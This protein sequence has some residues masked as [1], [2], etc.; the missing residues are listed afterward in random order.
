MEVPTGRNWSVQMGWNAQVEYET[1]MILQVGYSFIQ[2]DIF[3]FLAN[4]PGLL[5]GLFLTFTAYD[6][7]KD[8]KVS[9]APANGY[10]KDAI[11]R[12]GIL[13]GITC[14]GLMNELSIISATLRFTNF[15]LRV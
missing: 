8:E 4:E 10:I 11:L 15:K 1:L 14:N 7:C 6:L 13:S 5:L 3:V 2:R 9:P 12:L